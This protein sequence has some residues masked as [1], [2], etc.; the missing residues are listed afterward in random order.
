MLISNPSDTRKAPSNSGPLPAV[1]RGRGATVRRR[2]A[3]SNGSLTAAALAAES[4]VH[5][6]A[7]YKRHADEPSSKSSASW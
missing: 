7:L 6:M 3:G 4:G 2:A 5:R 1:G